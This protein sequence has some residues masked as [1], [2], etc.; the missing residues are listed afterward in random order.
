MKVHPNTLPAVLPAFGSVIAGQ[1]GMLAAILRG[2]IVDGIEQPPFALLVSD[3]TEGE[4]EDIAWGEYGKDVPGT[5]SRTDGKANTEAMA[6][7]NC[8]AALRVRELVI[9]GH[10]DWYLPSLGELNSAA[11]NVPELF[12]TE[13]YYWT[14]TQHSRLTAFVQDFEDGNSTW[15]DKGGER[16]VRAF[17]RTPLDALTT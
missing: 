1:G 6:L 5:S 2:P 17:R 11:A 9:D 13:D 14:S 3:A 4:F 10:S 8:P 15:G 12:S 16:R 7:T